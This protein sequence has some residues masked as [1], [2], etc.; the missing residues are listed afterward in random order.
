MKISEI[1]EF[2]LIDQI[3][4][5]FGDLALNGY[6]G[7][8]DDC[9]VLPY[10]SDE[11]LVVTTDLLIEDIHFLKNRILP[12]DLGYKSLAVNLSDIAA[13]GA[14]PAGSFLSI[15]IPAETE[16]AYINDFMEGYHELSLK[17]GVPLLGGDTTRSKH[18]LT[19]NVVVIGRCRKGEARL[20]SMA[21]PGDVI[22]VTGRLGD[23]AGGLQVLLK[24]LPETGDNLKL[25]AA[26]HMPEPHINEGK[27]LAKQP[28]VHA[29]MDVSDGISSDMIHI[30]KA[31]QQSARIDIDAIPVSDELQRLT[32]AEKWR[33]DEL[34]TSGGED[35]VLLLTLDEKLFGK[36]R[37]G[38][39]TL[40]GRDLAPIGTIEPGEP[41]ITWCKGGKVIVFGEHGFDHFKS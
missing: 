32:L 26:H 23:S 22:A 21:K 24:N 20:R 35:Y 15:G 37:S 34:I 38:F 12:H 33:I 14:I 27:W 19:I 4:A 2:G 17:Y 31:S 6:L 10:T 3:A 11:D 5:R 7:I 30:L 13:M 9:A 18:Y 16:G 39:N 1:G 29:M 28:A 8:G 36:V 41:H 25:I 40:F